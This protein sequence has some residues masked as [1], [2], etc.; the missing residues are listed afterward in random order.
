[1]PN[2]SQPASHVFSTI[3]KSRVETRSRKR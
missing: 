1:M 3:Y 2:E